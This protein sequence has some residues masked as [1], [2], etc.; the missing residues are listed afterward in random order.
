MRFQTIIT[1]LLPFVGGLNEREYRKLRQYC[2][3]YKF[4]SKGNFVEYGMLELFMSLS[5]PLQKALLNKSLF[6]EEEIR[7]IIGKYCV[8]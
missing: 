4:V 3:S 8:Y 2:K 6:A 7:T 5:K 1:D